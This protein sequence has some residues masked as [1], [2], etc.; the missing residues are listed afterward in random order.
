ML[1]QKSPHVNGQKPFR[2]QVILD[3]LNKEGVDPS[4]IDVF[5]GHGGSVCTQPSG[6]TMIDQKLYDDT[7]GGS[8]AAV[9]MPPSWA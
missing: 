4:D 5:A 2:Y 1:L 3:M 9:N 7:R 8:R 6:V